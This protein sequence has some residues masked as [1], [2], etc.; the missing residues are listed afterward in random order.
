MHFYKKI[1]DIPLKP[2]MLLSYIIVIL[3]CIVFFSLIVYYSSSS[4]I[5]KET[6][7]SMNQT[8]MLA[9]ENMNSYMNDIEK[10]LY[11]VQQNKR[12]QN[13][14]TEEPQESNIEINILEDEL[15]SIDTFRD[16]ITSINL[17][18]LDRKNYPDTY[19]NSIIFS[20]ELAENEPW[21]TKTLKN[22]GEVSWEAFHQQDT[23]GTIA[24]SRLIIDTNTHKPIA[25]VRADVDIYTFVQNIDNITIGKTGKL[26]LVSQNH[27][28][29]LGKNHYIKDFIN[30]NEFNQIIN[31]DLISDGYATINNERYLISY[32]NLKSQN[33]KIVGSVKFAE[34]NVSNQ[35]VA[36]AI[37]ITAFFS[38]LIAFLLMLIFSSW[39]T[40]PI[41]SL[42][43]IMKNYSKGSHQVVDIPSDDE[44]GTLYKSYNAMVSTIDNLIDDVVTLFQQ[45]KVSELKALQAQI[46]P[47]FLYNTLDSIKWLSKKNRSSDVTKIA[48]ALGKF[49]RHSLNKG[50][51]F[52]TIE[53]EINQI[54]SYADIQSIRF[55]DKFDLVID[56]DEDILKC[57]I[58]KLTL[59]P[60]VENSI[61][62]GFENI[63]YKG[64]IT[65]KGYFE[66]DY[67]II[68][69][70]DNGCGCDTDLLNIATRKEFNPD[71]PIET[72]GLHNVNQRIKLYFNN[73][74][75]L[76]FKK[77]EP[78]GVV[79]IV[80][81]EVRE[82]EYKTFDC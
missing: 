41:V 38:I 72:Y 70:K 34:I 56:V 23:K 10:T 24:A 40:V 49:F 51:E 46:N 32:A 54:I 47:H 28:I 16:R 60:L 77:N 73:T 19:N 65:I 50:Q 17:Y 71:E 36:T 30:N 9:K 3:I 52:T 29:D 67:I 66:D 53:N 64:I 75:G 13:V 61:L 55:K 57:T 2:K 39:I 33:F 4:I 21:F 63:D 27:I 5:E 62:H 26:F 48:T 81:L 20:S 78:Q 31:N 14:L 79:A 80:K 42:A 1:K 35:F 68:E 74:C 8:I 11:A 22:N 15:L 59:Q 76:S 25:V 37:L 58:V 18:V 45:Q 43:N 44:I 69:V 12:I 82:H 7:H 6:R